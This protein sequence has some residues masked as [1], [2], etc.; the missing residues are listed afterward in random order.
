MRII[1]NKLWQMTVSSELDNIYKDKKSRTGTGIR[2][3]AVAM[4]HP[5]LSLV[6]SCAELFGSFEECTAEI[7]QHILVGSLR[8]SHVH[9]LQVLAS[10]YKDAARFQFREPAM[11]TSAGLGKDGERETLRR[12]ENDT[13]RATDDNG[14][15]CGTVT[16]P[17]EDSRD[18]GECII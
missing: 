9:G 7:S 2:T 5:E 3:G 6:V 17:T 11:T 12:N 16:S 13:F 8:G 1:C 4:K 10:V 15:G 14:G 18:T